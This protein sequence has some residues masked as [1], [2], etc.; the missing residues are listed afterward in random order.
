M[1]AVICAL[2]VVGMLLPS[3]AACTGGSALEVEQKAP[4]KQAQMQQARD[5]YW[6]L[7]VRQILVWVGGA[8]FLQT[9]RYWV[10]R[11]REPEPEP[12]IAQEK[13]WEWEKN[14]GRYP[15]PWEQ[16]Q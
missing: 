12:D 8:C 4:Q 13:W 11:N 10:W 16:Q 6:V 7:I 1:R 14:D 5:N 9:I 2:I 3:M 15:P